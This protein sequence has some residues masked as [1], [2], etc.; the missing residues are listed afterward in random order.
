M[1]DL[2]WQASGEVLALADGTYTLGI[3]PHHITPTPPGV[4][5]IPIQD[6]VEITELSGSE[7]VAYFSLG[8][9]NWVSLA[10]G[11]HPYRV[12]E[13]HEFHLL[14]EQCFYFDGVGALVAKGIAHG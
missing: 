7:S 6:R 8:G 14:P 5:S 3:R 1:D 2:K 9:R 12:G 4:P 11:T 13:M 10:A